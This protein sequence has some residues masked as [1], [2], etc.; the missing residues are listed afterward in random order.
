[1][2]LADM[3]KE[4]GAQQ[5]L[6]QGLQQ[7]MEKG[8]VAALSETAIQ[9]LIDRFGKVPQDIKDGIVNSDTV[10]L[11]LLVVNSFKFQEVDEARRYI[12]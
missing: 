4:E 5:G 6:Q 9:I 10:T 1:M 12:Q 3:W 2:T 8:G 11:K 7:G